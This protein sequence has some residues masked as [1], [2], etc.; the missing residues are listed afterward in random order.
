MNFVSKTFLLI[1][2]NLFCKV[3]KEIQLHFSLLLL[4]SCVFEKRD[5]EWIFSVF[6]INEN[7][8]SEL[9]I[10]K[11]TNIIFKNSQS[12]LSGNCFKNRF[13]SSRL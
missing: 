8:G 4:L 11:Y 13:F 1:L 3:W 5:T 6:L 7:H 2:R 9:S 12:L 10:G